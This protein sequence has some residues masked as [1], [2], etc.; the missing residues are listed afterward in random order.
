MSSSS[1]LVRLGLALLLCG[2][3]AAAAA[4][5]WRAF[6]TPLFESV[7]VAD[8]LPHGT[9]TS[10]A[11]DRRGMIWMGT[12]GGLVRFDGHRMQVFRQDALDPHQLPDSYVRAIAPLADGRLLI[13]TNAGGLVVFDPATMRFDRLPVGAG[14]SAHAKIFAL[15]PARGGGYWAATEGGLDHV[16]LA[17]RRV[18]AVAGAPGAAPG[19]DP[20]SF[21]VLEDRRGNLWVGSNAGLLL[22]RAGARAFAPVAAA[23]VAGEILRD[24]I[25]ALHEDR[26]GRIWV[27]SG[28]TGLLFLDAGLQPRLVPGLSGV[29]GLARRRT[30]RAFLETDGGANGGAIWAATDGGG[31]VT[32]DAATGAAG[33][34]VHDPAMPASL[35]GDITRAL[36]EDRDGNVWIATE[37]GAARYNPA[38]RVVLSMLSSPLNPATLSDPNVHTVWVGPRGRVWLGLGMGRIDILDGERGRIARVRLTGEQAERDVQAFAIGPDGQVWAGSQGVARIDPDS[39]A[40]TGSAIPALDSKLILAMAVDGRDMLIGTYDGLFRYGTATRRLDRFVADPADPRS[41]AGNQVRLITRMPGNEFWFSTITGIS[42]ATP[43]RAGFTPLRNDPRDP[44]SLPHD[45]SGS[46]ERDSRGRTWLGTFGG[47]GILDRATPPYRFTR[48]TAADG[49]A[50]EKINALLTEG[51]R[52]WA[53][54]SDGVALIDG[55]RFGVRNL[56]P[57]DG[58][59]IDSYVHRAA[60]HAPDGALMFGGLGGLTVVRPD[61][62]RPPTARPQLAI[63]NLLVDGAALPF[64]AIPDAGRTLALAASRRGFRA[65]FALLDYRAP[66]ATRYSHR[67][68]GFDD[69]WVEVPFG[70]PPAAA[71]TNLPSGDYRLELR[72]ETGGLFPQTITL[73]TPIAVAPHWY[74]TLWFR[75]LCALAAVAAV[76]AIVALRTRLLRQRARRLEGLVD[77]RTQALRS[78][79][80]RL[81]ALAST[82]PLTGIGN[83]RRFLESATQELDLARRH[84]LPVSL[85]IVDLDRFKS[86]NDNYGHPVGD[87]VLKRAAEATVRACRPGDV[88]ARFGGEELVVLLPETAA[89]AALAAA[90]EV[91]RGLAVPGEFEGQAIAIT[92]SAGVAEWRAPDETLASLIERADRALYEAK[93]TGRDRAVLAAT[94]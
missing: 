51:E 40:V 6:D 62:V 94:G 70:T 4:D 36:L 68:R 42:V 35:P 47:I 67:L 86:I 90:E 65:D 33:R 92:A 3:A 85:I 43:G 59:V 8:G 7:R 74:E 56:G 53:S 22:R 1:L 58:L 38:G 72:A 66:A 81:A 10:L 25:W 87:A 41:L 20:R 83:R 61:A 21:A 45:Y 57:R 24:K 19:L 78:A 91:R 48:V 63:T 2:Q 49:L 52:A 80:D 84:G 9:V 23:G 46:I 32:W 29:D 34:I 37:V 13:G 30:V 54:T 28:Q 88:V 50:S 26:A 76:V 93:R 79:N 39:L 5:A 14:G 12:F 31:V 64:A 71:Y 15:A 11:Q 16:D 82:D 44:H 60:A 55:K 69:D 89:A 73:S 75:A 77:E 27:G 17:A 18:R